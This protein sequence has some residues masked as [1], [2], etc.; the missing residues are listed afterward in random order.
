[1]T[2]PDDVTMALAEAANHRQLKADLINNITGDVIHANTCVVC[3][4]D[5]PCTTASLAAEVER[6]S[7]LH[8]ARPPYRMSEWE[9]SE[10][11]ALL[12]RDA[13]IMQ[14]AANGTTD[15]E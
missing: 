1:M 3:L 9:P 11:A 10:L 8:A 2:T 15:E 7:R 12:E 6:L 4:M 13:A 5:W 14:A